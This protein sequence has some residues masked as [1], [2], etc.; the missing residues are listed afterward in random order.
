M[1]IEGEQNIN[2]NP[3]KGLENANRITNLT[4][5]A[6]IAGGLAML[7]DAIIDYIPDSTTFASA[8][9]GVVLLA[10]GVLLQ[11]INKQPKPD[12]DE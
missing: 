2:T 8:Y 3:D 12:S 9:S 5:I 4:S 1:P 10:T 11:K 7:T 6:F